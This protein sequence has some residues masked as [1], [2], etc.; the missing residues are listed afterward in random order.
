MVEP[1][2]EFTTVLVPAYAA[3]LKRI[4]CSCF[5]KHISI[6]TTALSV[7]IPME[8]TRPLSETR[9]SDIPA[10]FINTS[11]V[12]SEMGMVTPTMREPLRS[13]KK[14]NITIM[15]RAIPIVNVLATD[16]IVSSISSAAS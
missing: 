5:L 4:P 15:A 13:P 12:R 14:I 1:T 16:H 11:A 2:T 9:L 6:T 8:S 7:I 3:S 10:K